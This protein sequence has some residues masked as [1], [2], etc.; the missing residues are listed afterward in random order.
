MTSQKLY[1]TV[2]IY[3]DD[4]TFCL[5][6]NSGVRTIYLLLK[7][8]IPVIAEWVFFFFKT[9]LVMIHRERKL[10]Y[11]T[12]LAGRHFAIISTGSAASLFL[13]KRILTSS[14]CNLNLSGNL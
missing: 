14:P 2:S 11:S 6:E 12:S 8:Y 4:T 7:V 5:K 10:S 9:T 3:A 13:V 1:S